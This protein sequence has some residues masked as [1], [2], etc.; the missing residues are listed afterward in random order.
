MFLRLADEFMAAYRREGEAMTKREKPS[1]WPTPTRRSRTSPVSIAPGSQTRLAERL[2]ALITYR[3]W[4]FLS[5]LT[6][7]PMKA[8]AVRTEISRL[9]HQVPFRPFVLSME[10]G[11]RVSIGHPENIAFDPESDSP[12]FY[13][14][15]GRIR[16]FS[17]FDAVSN[18]ATADSVAH[19]SN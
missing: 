14:I 6:R 5:N 1:R 8:I 11:D 19:L 18:V 2:G 17:T 12:D 10:N 15:S 7:L 16:L 4:V 3:R 13:V 9:V